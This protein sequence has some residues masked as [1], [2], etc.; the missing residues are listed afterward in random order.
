MQR[1]PQHTISISNSCAL[2]RSWSTMPLALVSA[3]LMGLS[4]GLLI[5]L[6]LDIVRTV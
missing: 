3:L 4:A 6:M 1:T 2:D 5:V